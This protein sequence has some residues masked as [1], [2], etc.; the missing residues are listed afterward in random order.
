MVDEI[1][2]R[3]SFDTGGIDQIAGGISSPGTDIADAGRGITGEGSGGGKGVG[4]L[5]GKAALPLLALDQIGKG[6]KKMTNILEDASPQ[7]KATVDILRKS[8]LIFMRPFGD[9]LSAFIRPMAISLL[10]MS[11]EWLK[12]TRENKDLIKGIGDGLAIAIKG[13]IPGDNLASFLKDVVFGDLSLAE[14]F[15]QTAADRWGWTLDVA[16][17]LKKKFS[18]E[19]DFSWDIVADFFKP[20]LLGKWNFAFDFAGWLINKIET[21]FFGNETAPSFVPLASAGGRDI[22]AVD[23]VN[24]TNAAGRASQSAVVN[25]NALD[26]GSITPNVL[27]KISNAVEGVFRRGFS[28]VS[29]QGTA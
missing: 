8:F 4:G 18:N 3:I 19:W 15:T 20:M 7:F 29:S 22:T 13:I 27:D 24:S 14:W 16:T 21:F 2:A 23:I 12:W 17:W 6:I 11:I 25:V 26:A 28:G 1:K 10:R 5:L 9:A